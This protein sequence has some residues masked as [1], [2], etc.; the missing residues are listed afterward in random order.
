VAGALALVAINDAH[1]RQCH[2]EGM[3]FVVIEGVA[4]LV[5]IEVAF[6]QIVEIFKGAAY[7][8]VAGEVIT[9]MEDV[10]DGIA[11]RLATGNLYAIG[12]IKFR[13][14][15]F[16][17]HGLT[18]VCSESYMSNHGMAVKPV[19]EPRGLSCK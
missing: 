11:Y 14:A 1:H 9:T 19:T 12:D 5:A 6:K 3:L 8:F 15:V 7:V 18:G 2:V 10:A 17:R 13:V 4:A 16:H